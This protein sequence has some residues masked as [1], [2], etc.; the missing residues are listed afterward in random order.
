MG[1][2][3]IAGDV[4]FVLSMA[5]YEYT[6][7]EVVDTHK[8]LGPSNGLVIKVAEQTTPYVCEGYYPQSV[9]PGFLY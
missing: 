4:V 5:L 9:I 3:Y 1:W 8:K 2:S 7:R 6:S